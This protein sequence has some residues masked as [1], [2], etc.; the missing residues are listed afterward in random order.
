[1]VA[2][3][4]DPVLE[5]W[6]AFAGAAGE[7]S[8]ARPGE[9][10]LNLDIGGGTTNPAVGVGG[11]VV[12][13]G[14]LHVGARHIRV[15]PGTHDVVGATPLGQR[16][17]DDADGDVMAV[18]ARM[19][20][21]LEAVTLGRDVEPLLLA[22]RTAVPDGARVV[23]SGGVGELVYA[24]EPSEPGRFGDLG[25]ELAEAILASDVLGVRDLVPE[26][27]G[28]A[29][30]YGVA[31]HAT[32][33][34]GATVHVDP[35]MLPLR[36]LPILARLEPDHRPER[37]AAAMALVARTE[38]G[39]CIQI[40]AG[41]TNSLARVRRLG[42]QLARALSALPERRVLVLLLEDDAA[43]TL[44]GYATRWGRAGG[45]LVVLDQLVPRDAAFVTVGSSRHGV[46][47]VAFHGL[48]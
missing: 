8:R 18:V 4:S 28:R 13:A 30:V 48:R 22:V 2:V 7:L 27:R 14:C 36:D 44:G 21:A 42:E 1:V 23:L 47:P 32:E 16:L 45:D 15:R 43:I 31:L 19:T 5:S 39:G 41:A 17:L 9:A 37:L 46:V 26:H 25:G 6:L 29:T 11:D 24:G 38:Q 34:S 33:I 3:A 35:T 10:I 40:A 12:A 20:R